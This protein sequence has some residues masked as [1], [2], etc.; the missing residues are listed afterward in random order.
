MAPINI[1]L[2]ALGIM[3]AMTI[4]SCAPPVEI[5]KSEKV[6]DHN[7]DNSIIE[8]DPFPETDKGMTWSDEAVA[9][10]SFPSPQSYTV[11]N[12]NRQYYGEI[13]ITNPGSIKPINGVDHYYYDSKNC[14]VLRYRTDSYT[15][16]HYPPWDFLKWYGHS[17]YTVTD[18][19][20]TLMG[21]PI[22]TTTP[23]KFINN[24]GY[25]SPVVLPDTKVVGGVETKVYRMWVTEHTD[26]YLNDAATLYKKFTEKYTVRYLESADNG[27]S[28]AE[29]SDS[30]AHGLDVTTHLNDQGGIIVTDVKK[31]KE[32]YFMWYRAKDLANGESKTWRMY[33]AIYD[34]SLNRWERLNSGNLNL[35]K[36]INPNG[37]DSVN[38]G[39]G[40][41]MYDEKEG[42]YMMWYEG[43]DG[44]TGKIGYSEARNPRY[45]SVENSE[46]YKSTESRFDKKSV[47]DPYVIKDGD[48]Y[49]MWYSGFDGD[50]WRLGLAYSWDGKYF[51]YSDKVM[52]K[53]LDL[54][55]YNSYDVRHP[56]VIK[57][58][59]VYRV[60]MSVRDRVGDNKTW[61][62]AYIQSVPPAT[63]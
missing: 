15:L 51:E 41:A 53:E 20:V 37:F 11:P 8:I 19:Y 2:A 29:V 47:N 28:W 62:I 54:G 40:S 1:L 34:Y 59:D 42:K 31:I 61:Q 9:P 6:I 5:I 25:I 16:Y 21:P 56:F 17:P 39:G 26:H 52:H 18:H 63:P 44:K 50:Q 45:W 13:R 32:N 10:K 14:E 30:F 38:I 27:L 57:E 24:H 3:A 58:G 36:D 46:I 48:V 60:W 49:K 35:V 43:S 55:K 7:D 33:M 23:T 12:T 4:T 22:P